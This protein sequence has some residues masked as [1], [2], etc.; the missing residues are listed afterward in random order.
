M[1]I[2]HYATVHHAGA[3]ICT[4]RTA[5]TGAVRLQLELKVI[6]DVGL[7]GF[8][9]VGK[10]TLFSRVTNAQTEDRQLSFYN[11]ESAIWAWWIWTAAKDLSWRI[12]RD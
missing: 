9:N 11:P 5:G 3:E 10:S 6:A 2:M 1:A 12:F 4:A 8:P 7:V